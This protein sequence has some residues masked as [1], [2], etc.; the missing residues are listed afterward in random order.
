M[1]LRTITYILHHELIDSAPI[2]HSVSARRRD[3]DGEF[4]AR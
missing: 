4:R 2:R 1:S 3:S